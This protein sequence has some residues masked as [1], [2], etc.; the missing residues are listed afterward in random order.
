M[1]CSE[2]GEEGAALDAGVDGEAGEFEEGGGK[3]GEFGEGGGSLAGGGGEA[4]GVGD[5]ERDVDGGGVEVGAF[6]VDAVVAE[7]FA[8]VGHEDDD[9]VVEL[10]GLLE[11]VDHAT[12]LDVDEVAHGPV[13]GADEAVLG[14]GHGGG[15]HAAAVVDR[16]V[17]GLEL[18]FVGQFAFDVVGEG[19]LVEDFEVAVE[20]ILGRVE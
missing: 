8:V 6:E 20:K 11:G 19:N 13:G 15:V 1:R 16:L 18:R 5:D 9:G 17:H 2:E 7:H 4:G 10:V 14:G 12:D 3:I